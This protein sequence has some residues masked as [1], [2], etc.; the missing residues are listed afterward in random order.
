[1]H[2]DEDTGETDG[3][4]P[5]LTPMFLKST[6]KE[7]NPNLP[8]CGQEASYDQFEEFIKACKKEIDSLGDGI[9]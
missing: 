9:T 5:S 3:F 2:T 7:N 8:S 6:K 1:M 4:I